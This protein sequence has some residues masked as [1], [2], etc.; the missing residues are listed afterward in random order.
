MISLCPLVSLSP[1]SP[2]PLRPLSQRLV[3]SVASRV[4]QVNPLLR[5]RREACCNPLACMGLR[6]KI[7]S[8]TAWR[9]WRGFPPML[10][11]SNTESPPPGQIVPL[12]QRAQAFTPTLLFGNVQPPNVAFPQH[13]SPRRTGDHPVPGALAKEPSSPPSPSASPPEGPPAPQH[14]HDEPAEENWPCLAP[15]RRLCCMG[16]H[17]TGILMGRRGP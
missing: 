5:I 13:R 15:G 1:L 11:K 10:Q 14:M 12:S 7:F 17:R 8:G 3:V 4:P 16:L 6:G 9:A 2:L